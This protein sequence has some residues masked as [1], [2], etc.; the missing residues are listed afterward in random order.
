M[1]ARAHYVKRHEPGTVFFRRALQC[2]F[3]YG[4]TMCGRIADSLE[5]GQDWSDALGPWPVQV[6]PSFNKAP[7]ETVAAFT[8]EGGRA[9]R[10]GL[11]PAW[12]KTP[13]IKYATFNA[14]VEDM[15][16]KPAYRNAWN[17]SRRCVI[18]V[19]GYYEWQ[20]LDGRK[21][22][23]FIHEASGEP[24]FLAG[25]W[26]AWGQNDEILL[27]CT[28]LTRDAARPV[29]HIHNRMPVNGPPE[30]LK[31]WL[32]GPILS[33]QA[34]IDENGSERLDSYPVSTYVNN[35]RNEGERCIAPLSTSA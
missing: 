27:S 6:A 31:E 17:A 13:A 26:E 2:R 5:W 3:R 8:G 15:A 33:A 19:M 20:K 32:E 18:P 7:T 16:S 11:V 35:A 9:M 4:S 23:Y 24:L 29:A 28:I 1:T 34:I 22:P 12:S 14:R 25:L 30:M 10:W 21:Q